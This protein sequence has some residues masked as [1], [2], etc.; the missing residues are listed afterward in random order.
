M[1]TVD[2]TGQVGA[3]G[4][5]AALLAGSVPARAEQP[6]DRVFEQ[7]LEIAGAEARTVP[8]NPVQASAPSV[9]ARP[10]VAP[11]PRPPWTPLS[12]VGLGV[13]GALGAGAAV[14]GSLADRDASDVRDSSDERSV[15]GDVRDRSVRAKNL[16]LASDLLLGDAVLTA[17]LTLTLT[18]VRSPPSAEASG[19]AAAPRSLGLTPGGVGL[20]HRC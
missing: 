1:Q 20:R 16:A 10:A 13:A 2:R 3:Q 8:I 17:G 19:A 7:N 11:E 9:V 4:L 5:C 18:P 15:D 12:W 14:T 6:G